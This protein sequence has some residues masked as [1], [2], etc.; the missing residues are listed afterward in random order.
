MKIGTEAK[1]VISIV[2]ALQS[3]QHKKMSNSQSVGS[4]V[5]MFMFYPALLL[6]ER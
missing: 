1:V 4:V 5:Y 3:L 6:V 2:P